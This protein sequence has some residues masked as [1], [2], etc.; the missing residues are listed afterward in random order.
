MEVTEAR[1]IVVGVDGSSASA[2]AL[3]WAV[4]HARSL[5]AEVHAVLGWEV[6]WTIYLVPTWTEA[7][8]E[9]EAQRL[10]D[11]TVKEA[12]GDVG[13]VRVHRHLA[14]QKP[15]LA[16]VHAAEGAELL[17][18]GATGRGELPGMH[19]GSV[20]GYCVHHAPCPVMVIRQ[21]PEP[22]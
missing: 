17:V 9:A 12:L 18:V 19:L 15:A 16:L 20:A 13:D 14:L 10:L 2:D 6:P 22:G 7:D 21:R 5:G 3:R 8:Y 11:H 4:G 1:R